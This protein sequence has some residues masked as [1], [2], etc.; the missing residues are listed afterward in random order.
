MHHATRKRTTYHP[1]AQTI[2][3][4][5][6]RTLGWTPVGGRPDGVRQCVLVAGPHR[7][8][9]DLFYMLLTAVALNIPV[10]FLMK[11]TVFWWPLGYLWRYLGGIP[12]NRRE[13]TNAVEQVIHAFETHPVLYL[14]ITPEGSRKNVGT[15]KSG[16]YHIAQGAQVPIL[17][18]FIDYP[19]KSAGT[20]PL[21]PTTGDLIADFDQLA[22]FYEQRT[23]LRP[24]L[25]K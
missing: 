6:L 10:T 13:R 4:R 20:G 24:T 21:L 9:W 11:D 18:A 22:D 14:V 25:S 7:T 17:T 15:W 1:A 3:R 19:S 23:S 2:A 16:F 12:V 8:N 5:L